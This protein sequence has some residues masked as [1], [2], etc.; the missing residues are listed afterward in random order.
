MVSATK[1]YSVKLSYGSLHADMSL[2]D[3]QPIRKKVAPELHY[4]ITDAEEI[5][6]TDRIFFS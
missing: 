4:I 6:M 5:S 3:N 2:L 1:A